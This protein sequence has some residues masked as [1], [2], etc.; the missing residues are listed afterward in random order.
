MISSTLALFSGKWLCPR[1]RVMEDMPK[2]RGGLSWLVKSSLEQGAYDKLYGAIVLSVWTSIPGTSLWYLVALFS[3]SAMVTLFFLLS[4]C[5]RYV[6]KRTLF[7][8]LSRCCSCA[9]LR[10]VPLGR[11]LRQSCPLTRLLDS[12]SPSSGSGCQCQR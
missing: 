6:N 9:F 12:W 11:V 8:L 7:F 1:N 4:R 5:C 2:G 10:F 3:V